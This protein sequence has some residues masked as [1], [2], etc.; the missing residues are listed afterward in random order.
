M[1]RV[2]VA[3]QFDLE[4]REAIRANFCG[5]LEADFFECA[6]LPYFS[7]LSLTGYNGSRAQRRGVHWE[8]HQGEL[9]NRPA[10]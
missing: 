5:Q 9:K 8:T 1:Q 10:R 2:D 6:V 4:V 3:T 7:L